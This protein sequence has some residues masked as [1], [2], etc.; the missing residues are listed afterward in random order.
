MPRKKRP[1]KKQ[2]TKLN[3]PALKRGLAEAVRHVDSCL[4][5]LEDTGDDHGIA[6]AFVEVERR[7]TQLRLA[8]GKPVDITKIEDDVRAMDD[9]KWAAEQAKDAK[10]AAFYNKMWRRWN[11]MP[12]LLMRPV[13]KKK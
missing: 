9:P 1:L 6:A 12:A 8:T 4:A 10:A 7:G 13:E 3:I 5:V 2:T 11:E